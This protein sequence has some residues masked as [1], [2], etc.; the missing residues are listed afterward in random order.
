MAISIESLKSSGHTRQPVVVL[1]GVPGVGKTTLA[2]GAPDPVAMWIEKGAGRLKIPGWEI[3]SYQDV[4]DAIG[5]LYNEEHDR[6]TLIV[7]SLDWLEKLVWDET[8]T[9]NGWTTLEDPGYGKGY[10]A[11]LRV[12]EEFL[13][14]VQDLRVD[15][16]MM[17]VLIAHTE[18]KRFDA[19]DTEPYDRYQIKL[20]AKA[21]AKISESADVVGFLNFRVSIAKTD[22]SFGKKVARG[23]GGGQRV[24]HLNERPSAVAKQRFGMPDSLEIPTVKDAWKDP[25]AL[26]AVIAEHIPE[27]ESK[28]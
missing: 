19:P 20:H 23:V 1:Y 4:L 27:P 12:W 10:M 25:A 7:D 24:L 11:A 14:G 18:I 3:E 26:W 13:Q 21:A 22:A 5:A 6:K 9:R 8:C 16:G 28:E 2:C 17:I 15:R